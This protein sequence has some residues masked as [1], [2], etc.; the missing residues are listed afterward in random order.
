MI[1]HISAENL[2]RNLKVQLLLVFA[3]VLFIL[4]LFFSPVES[5]GLILLNEALVISAV[6]FLL[7]SINDFIS[8]GKFNLLSLVMNLGILNAIM[9]FFITFSDSILNLFYSNLGDKIKNPD[10]I[11]TIISFFYVSIFVSSLCYIF[12]TFKQFYFTGHKYERSI[13]FNTMTIFFLLSVSTA[14][15]D[16]FPELSYINHTFLIISI[17]LIGINSIRI[18]WIAFLSKKEKLLLLILS[19]VI[20]TL[21]I[22][23]LIKSGDDTT[24]YKILNGFSPA[25]NNF[26][27]LMMIY[28][29]GYFSILFFT[30]LFHIPT[31]EAYDRKAKEVSSLQYFSRLI[32]QVLDFND[33]A[34]TITDIAIKVCNADASWISLK[35]DGE[36]RIV[37]NKNIGFVD[38]DSITKYILNESKPSLEKLEK[39]IYQ[40]SP[41]HDIPQLSEKYSSLTVS[42]L[43][44]HSEIKGYL[45]A[46]KKG[47][48]IFDDEDKDA[49]NT[50][51]DYASVAIENAKLLEESIEKQ[52]LEKE[53]DVAREIQKKILPSKN[54][55][56]DGLD[57][58]STFIPAFEVGGD[59]Y[60]FFEI[61]ENKLGFVIADVSG[62]GISAAFIMAE[63][64]GIFESLSQTS[65]SPKEILINANQILR[66]TLDRKS[67]VSAA[68]GLLDLNEQ[69]L[70]LARAGHCPILLLRDGV[71]QDIR[72]SG[73]GLGL[74]YTAYFASTLEEIKLDLK[75]NDVLVLFTDGIT[76]AKNSEKEDFGEMNFEK[77]LIENSHLSAEEISN[78]VIKGVTLFSQNTTQHDDITLV[79]FKFKQKF[80]LFGEKEWQNSV[81]Q[82][83]TRVI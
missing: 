75:E 76:E 17:I 47:D 62:K 41:L 4:K 44:V 7:F 51:T 57:I 70:F 32:T 48:S 56:Y 49:L 45:F 65:L 78:E 66:R 36:S 77:I 3:A 79:I 30:T 14:F 38:A 64:K 13:Y 54:P 55:E 71:T 12:L 24:H 6:A 67:F 18:S 74:N 69:K 23:N 68:Y 63:V 25:L 2:L 73:L 59:Y 81:L 22:L 11:Y 9:F 42:I 28:G 1:R 21:F 31:A 27:Q 82:S 8:S 19:V 52:R 35:Q 37:A 5:F 72:P 60:D 83:K 80:N 33:L 43:R 58:S 50:F 16:K 26:L 20:L 46:A 10:L 39:T 15:L 29:I 34:E 53:L 61:T 40:L